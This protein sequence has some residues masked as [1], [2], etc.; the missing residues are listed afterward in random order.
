MDPEILK[1]N[2]RAYFQRVLNQ[3]DLSAL[4]ELL[5]PDY[6]DHDAPAS[7][8][9]GPEPVRVYLQDFLADM[10]EL[11]VQ[12]HDVLAEGNRAA[13]RVEWRGRRKDGILFHE[14]GVLIVRFDEQGRLAERWS[15][16]Q[17]L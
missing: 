15:G 4:E 12:V 16:Y 2:L 3:R 10:P 5:A 13:A 11:T 14:A 9:T 17:L 7:S 6:T 8:P 1:A